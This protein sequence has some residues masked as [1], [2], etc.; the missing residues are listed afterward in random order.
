[1]NDTI[2]NPYSLNVVVDTKPM[3]TTYLRYAAQTKGIR[4][5]TYNSA[6]AFQ[7]DLH[8]FGSGTTFFFGQV[9]Y[10]ECLYGTDLAKIVKSKMS[11]R[12]FIVTVLNREIRE[13]SPAIDEGHVDL[14]LPKDIYWSEPCDEEKLTVNERVN[15]NEGFEGFYDMLKLTRL[16]FTERRDW[17]KLIRY[18][19][20]S[21]TPVP[22]ATPKP[23]AVETQIAVAPNASAAHDKKVAG[24]F[25]SLAEFFKPSRLRP[26][27]A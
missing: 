24:W 25:R 22:V 26:N 16:A 13:F 23:I 18:I 5:L 10:G 9:F 15:L 8:L 12:T 4:L 17:L 14:V 1:M 20:P 11:C 21:R 7:K 3:F 6:I 19:E 2:F 27:P